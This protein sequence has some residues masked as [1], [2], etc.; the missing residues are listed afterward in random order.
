[1]PCQEG[2]GVSPAG[3]TGLGSASPSCGLPGFPRWSRGARRRATALT[4][5][6]Q[7]TPRTPQIRAVRPESAGRSLVSPPRQISSPQLRPLGARRR[8]GAQGAASSSSS[9]PSRSWLNSQPLSQK[10]PVSTPANAEPAAHALAP[11]LAST[12]VPAAVP[13]RCRHPQRTLTLTVRSPTASASAAHVVAKLGWGFR[14]AD[15][16]GRA[17]PSR[18][19]P[20]RPGPA[21]TRR[22]DPA[23]RRG[24]SLPRRRPRRRPRPGPAARGARPPEGRAASPPAPRARSPQGSWPGRADSAP[25]ATP[26]LPG[27]PLSPPG[28]KDGAG[29][30]RRPRGPGATHAASRR[31]Q[32][33]RKFVRPGPAAS[34]APAGLGLGGGGGGA[35]LRGAGAT[36]GV[37]PRERTPGARPPRAAAPPAKGGPRPQASSRPEGPFTQAGEP[38]GD[39]LANLSLPGPRRAWRV[40][41][42]D[43]PSSKQER[44]FLPGLDPGTRKWLGWDRASGRAVVTGH[45]A[46]HLAGRG[47]ESRGT[48]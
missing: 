35:A 45:P 19:H 20:V 25:A 7:V 13:R 21:V 12:H 10:A 32:P 33:R 8:R 15:A 9:R 46:P 3:H 6:P 42:C 43:R 22:G 37:R 31:P 44:P 27:A 5:D 24:P 30:A 47:R 14:G 4:S 2:I 39:T 48:S 38:S 26:H 11:P 41:R 36:P 23:P 34:S 18:R 28:A 1:M 29:D 17:V 16:R 40:S